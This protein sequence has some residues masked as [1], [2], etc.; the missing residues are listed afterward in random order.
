MPDISGILMSKNSK[1]TS[2]LF[3]YSIAS[4]AF[5][6]VAPNCK[7]EILATYF[8]I[9]SNAMGSSSIAIASAFMPY[10]IGLE[11]FFFGKF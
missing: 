5:T 8:F 9:I 1:S 11:A 6:N 10:E 7:N 2:F 3:K 4:K